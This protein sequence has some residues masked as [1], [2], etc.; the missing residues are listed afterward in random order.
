MDWL[1]S[2]TVELVQLGAAMVSGYTPP[3]VQTTHE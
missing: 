1:F 2:M 3:G